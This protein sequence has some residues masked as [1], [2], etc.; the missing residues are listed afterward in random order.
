MNQDEIYEDLLDFDKNEPAKPQLDKAEKVDNQ[1]QVTH[2]TN[3]VKE[4][5]TQKTVESNKIQNYNFD[6]LNQQENHKEQRNLN[7]HKSNKIEKTSFLF[8]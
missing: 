8:S 4:I 1:T 6:Y 5:S 3:T 2:R 7:Q